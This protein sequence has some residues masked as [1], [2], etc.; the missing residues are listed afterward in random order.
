MKCLL[1]HTV[2]SFIAW[3]VVPVARLDYF[4]AIKLSRLESFRVLKM[5]WPD[6][7]N[8]GSFRVLKLSRFESVRGS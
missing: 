1:F 6:W 5:H 2:P 7:N 3:D 8:L 4:R